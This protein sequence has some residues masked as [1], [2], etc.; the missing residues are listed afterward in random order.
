M[1][2]GTVSA[3]AGGFPAVRKDLGEGAAE[4]WLNLEELVQQLAALLLEPH[5][6]LLRGLSKR[7]HFGRNF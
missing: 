3:P 7:S 5:D 2:P 6:L 4:Q 1:A